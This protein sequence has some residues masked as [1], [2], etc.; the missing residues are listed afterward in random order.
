MI[1]HLTRLSTRSVGL[2]PVSLHHTRVRVF[3]YLIF[4][5]SIREHPYYLSSM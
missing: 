3:G 4:W 5:S 1:K 2:I